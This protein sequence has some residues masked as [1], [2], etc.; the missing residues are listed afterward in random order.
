MDFTRVFCNTEYC[1]EHKTI[2]GITN[3]R[4]YAGKDKKILGIIPS[5]KIVHLTGIYALEPTENKKWFYVEYNGICGF[6]SE[7]MI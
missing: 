7:A 3:I 2:G 6:I 1:G 4:E 5:N